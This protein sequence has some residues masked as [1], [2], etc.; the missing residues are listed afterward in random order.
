[1]SKPEPI[2]STNFLTIR[3]LAVFLISAVSGLFGLGLGLIGLPGHIMYIGAVLLAA[4]L[5][6]FNVFE[7]KALHYLLEKEKEQGSGPDKS[8]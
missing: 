6:A 5:G 7:P 3:F 2:F 4:I 8:I 1:M